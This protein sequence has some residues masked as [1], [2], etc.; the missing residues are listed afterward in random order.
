VEQWF[1]VRGDE[2]RGPYSRRELEDFVDQRRLARTDLVWCAGMADWQEAGSVPGLFPARP[3]PTAEPRPISP[4]SAPGGDDSEEEAR[5]G[6]RRRS[7]YPGRLISPGFFVLA[8]LMFLVPWVDIRCNN[9]PMS[10]TVITQSGLQSCWGGYSVLRES[11]FNQIANQP[12]GGRLRT[13]RVQPAPLMII[14]ATLLLAGMALGTALP[15]GTL[16]FVALSCVSGLA[17]MLMV[18][19]FVVGFPIAEP[20]QRANGDRNLIQGIR[21]QAGL[22]GGGPRGRFG[23]A[24]NLGDP[25]GRRE[26][27]E[28]GTTPWFWLAA[29]ATLGPFGGLAMEHVVVFGRRP[30]RRRGGRCEGY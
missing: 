11:E 26:L 2:S 8:G 22:G 15:I 13:E 29:F 30:S 14:Y 1:I 10:M 7:E 18:V 3:E 23:G 4:R 9:G 12:A 17:M 20:V 27:L 21:Q 6:P 16:R 25:F 28:A 24:P 5:P 19:Q